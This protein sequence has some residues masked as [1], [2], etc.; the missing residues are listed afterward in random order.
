MNKKLI[1][2]VFGLLYD[3]LVFFVWIPVLLSA[4]F[5][6][7][8]RKFIRNRSG[9]VHICKMLDS[10]GNKKT[11]W[12]YCASIGEFEQAIPLISAFE[13]NSITCNIFF[14]SINGYDHAKKLNYKNIS[15]TPFDFFVAWSVLQLIV[16]LKEVLQLT[17]YCWASVEQSI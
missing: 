1:S 2:I 3:L 15:L 16:L 7:N 9:L 4:P 17:L 14:H 6:P 12:F 13:N 8:V 5:I 11:A 10:Q